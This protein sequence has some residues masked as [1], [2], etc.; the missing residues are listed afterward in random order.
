M[1]FDI[2]SWTAC[3]PLLSPDICHGV[4]TEKGQQA[5]RRC[6]E[7]AW[8]GISA[9]SSHEDGVDAVGANS[10]LMQEDREERA[11]YESPRYCPFLVVQLLAPAGE[12]R[13][14]TST[15]VSRLLRETHCHLLR[16][17]RPKGSLGHNP[18][19]STFA[20]SSL[21]PAQASSTGQDGGPIRITGGYSQDGRFGCNACWKR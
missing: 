4:E 5:E 10:C 15:A 18:G 11:V 13:R 20:M 7:P 3:T 16:T 6:L 1:M 17:R 2:T 14:K 21:S 12:S 8:G 9:I 19:V